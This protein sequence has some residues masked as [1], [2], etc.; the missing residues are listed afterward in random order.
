MKNKDT[1]YITTYKVHFT[2]LQ[3]WH[4]HLY[5]N[6]RCYVAMFKQEQATAIILQQRDNRSAK[7]TSSTSKNG[8]FEEFFT[9]CR[10]ES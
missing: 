3:L 8:E 4:Q 2:R 6:L 7:K 9:L 5:L 10:I 1:K